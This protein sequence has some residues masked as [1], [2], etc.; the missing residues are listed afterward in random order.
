MVVDDGVGVGDGGGVVGGGV[1]GAGLV[2]CG[3]VG[4]G[5]PVCFGDGDVEWPGA[6]EV[7]E[8]AGDD[9]SVDPVG[10]TPR[11]AGPTSGR[12]GI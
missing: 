7:R 3:G 10:S 9:G 5:D 6:G 4:V 12:A 11:G 2:A 8:G 1:V